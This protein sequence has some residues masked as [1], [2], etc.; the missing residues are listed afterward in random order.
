MAEG[1][2]AITVRTTGAGP[3]TTLVIDRLRPAQNNEEDG[4]V[5]F[6]ERK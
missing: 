1:H 5:R 2:L 6:I 4:I 3:A